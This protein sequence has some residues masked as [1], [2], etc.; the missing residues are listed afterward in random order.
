MRLAF[1]PF[2]IHREAQA[3]RRACIPYFGASLITGLPALLMIGVPASSFTGT[4][5]VT[6]AVTWMGLKPRLMRFECDSTLPPPLGNT[7]PRSP[8]GHTSFHS[9]RA[10]T[11]RVGVG[12]DRYPD[13]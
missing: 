3:W 5:L 10:L 2:S 4:S 13:C 11:T 7:R 12:T 1:M 6:P 8:R 9:R